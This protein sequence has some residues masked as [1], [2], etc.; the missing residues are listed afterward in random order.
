M[1]TKSSDPR[2]PNAVVK[3]VPPEFNEDEAEIDWVGFI[4]LIVGK[5]YIYYNIITIIK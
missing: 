4:A 1:S 2:R 5:Y 3:F